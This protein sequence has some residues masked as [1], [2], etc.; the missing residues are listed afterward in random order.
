[1]P[2]ERQV[3]VQDEAEKSDGHDSSM[4]GGQRNK[5]A[6]YQPVIG[7]RPVNYVNRQG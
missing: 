4:I 7:G 5:I 3:G 1:V 2:D 6:L